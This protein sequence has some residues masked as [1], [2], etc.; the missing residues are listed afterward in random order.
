MQYRWA[1]CS[2]VVEES[3]KLII[4]PLG[5]NDSVATFQLATG[6]DQFRAFCTTIEA[7][8]TDEEPIAMASTEDNSIMIKE[9]GKEEA[10]AVKEPIINAFDLNGLD[11]K[12][13]ADLITNHKRHWVCI[14][15][16]Q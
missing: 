15:S 7:V 4:V 1:S 6:Y 3:V 5:D 12:D 13:P 9:E 8:T 10:F 14:K 11:G 2:I 16:H